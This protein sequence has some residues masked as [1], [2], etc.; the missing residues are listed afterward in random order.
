MSGDLIA[1]VSKPVVHIFVWT[2]EIEQAREI[3][4]GNFRGAKFQ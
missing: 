1:Q 3:V 4:S 2:G